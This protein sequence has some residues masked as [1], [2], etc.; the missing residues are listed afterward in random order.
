V[1]RQQNGTYSSAKV[2]RDLEKEAQECNKE[3]EGGRM[4]SSDRR[5]TTASPKGRITTISKK[6]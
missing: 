1:D 6:S 4:P 2:K 5:E 3:R